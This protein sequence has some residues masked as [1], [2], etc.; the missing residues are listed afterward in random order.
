MD[1]NI[2]KQVQGGS[3][4]EGRPASGGASG[5]PARDNNNNNNNNNRKKGQKGNPKPAPVH[6][7]V[8]DEEVQKQIKDTLARLTSKGPKFKTAK[9]RRD[10][11]EAVSA[12]MQEEQAREEREMIF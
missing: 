2:Q 9:H 5:R 4:S 3:R 7:E 1:L 8:S 6:V 10:K 11:R 12:R